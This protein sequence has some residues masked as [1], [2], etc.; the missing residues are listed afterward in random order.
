MSPTAPRKHRP[1]GQIESCT[2]DGSHSC[3]AVR[4]QAVVPSHDGRYS[5]PRAADS[6]L[7]WSGA[8]FAVGP[9]QV[10]PVRVCGAVL[11]TMALPKSVRL[12]TPP[13][14]SMLARVPHRWCGRRRI[15]RGFSMIR[16]HADSAD[17]PCPAWQCVCR[18]HSNQFDA[19]LTRPQFSSRK[20]AS[21]RVCRLTFIK[22]GSRNGN[23]KRNIVTQTPHGSGRWWSGLL[24]WSSACD[25]RRTR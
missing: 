14:G 3:R 23:N 6:P 22:V 5:V 13:R 16:R 19:C 7:R 21:T 25:G 18:G 4:L 12:W 17:Q 8:E 10:L 9:E 20:P 2:F 11:S 1:T 15:D 24:H